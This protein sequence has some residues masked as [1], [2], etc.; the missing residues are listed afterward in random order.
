MMGYVR[1]KCSQEYKIFTV[2]ILFGRQI[3]SKERE[4]SVTFGDPDVI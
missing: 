4:D 3:K 2:R 1:S